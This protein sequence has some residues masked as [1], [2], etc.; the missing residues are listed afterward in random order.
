MATVMEQALAGNAP[1]THKK[2]SGVSQTVFEEVKG[3]LA[4]KGNKLKEMAEHGRE[5]GMS[6]L[7]T[8]ETQLA[9]FATSMA[10][11][12]WGDDK[13]KMGKLPIPTAV[14]LGLIGW[15][16][17]DELSGA[18]GGHQLA[19]GNGLLASDVADLGRETGAKLAE[20]W[21]KKDETPAQIPAPAPAAAPG[22]GAPPP[23]KLQGPIRELETGREHTR[24]HGSESRAEQHQIVPVRVLNLR[25]YED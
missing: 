16:L 12:A 10:K 13:L 6:A 20:S 22:G 4:R 25:D 5:A 8:G 14:G 2:K 17:Y 7:H 1:V 3:Q 15:G 23:V 11:G 19:I 21:K 24:R 18:G 9:V